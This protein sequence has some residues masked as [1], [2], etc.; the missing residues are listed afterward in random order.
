[1]S[2]RR[3]CD[4]PT[5]RQR[6]ERIAALRASCVALLDETARQYRQLAELRLV[7]C[8]MVR[9]PASERHRLRAAAG[10]GR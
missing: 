9:A 10:G 2:E 1:M 6:A 3:D 7:E 5:C 8:D 4:C